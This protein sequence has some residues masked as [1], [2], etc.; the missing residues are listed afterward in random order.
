MAVR[1]LKKGVLDLTE[2]PVIVLT[3]PE[4]TCLIVRYGSNFVVPGAVPV[5][6]ITWQRTAVPLLD[7]LWRE[8]RITVADHPARSPVA[9]KLLSWP[10]RTDNKS[11]SNHIL[12]DSYGGPHRQLHVQLV[13]TIHYRFREITTMHLPSEAVTQQASAVEGA[14]EALDVWL[15]DHLSVL[16]F[17]SLLVFRGC[18]WEIFHL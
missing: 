16:I 12:V 17:C 13:R 14:W 5:L 1:Y 18:C 15:S 10:V 8:W 7:R 9:G 3:P 11:G 6:L 2:L 4:H